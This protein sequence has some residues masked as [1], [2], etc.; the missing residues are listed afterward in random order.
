MVV[1]PVKWF[2]SKEKKIVMRREYIIY[3][4]QTKA[5]VFTTIAATKRIKYHLSST[6]ITEK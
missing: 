4:H 5:T 2:C 6:R 1:S 3:D